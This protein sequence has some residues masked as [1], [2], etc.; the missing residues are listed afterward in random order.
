MTTGGFR[1]VLV[2]MLVTVCLGAGSAGAWAQAGAPVGATA[3][4]FAG[5]TPTGGGSSTPIAARRDPPRRV[6]GAPGD[7]HGQPAGYGGTLVYSSGELVYQDHL[8]DAWG[9]DNGQNTRRLAIQDP[10]AALLPESY[11]LDPAI[12]YVPYEFG[13]PTPGMDIQTHYGA[14]S[15]QEQADLSELRVGTE[16]SRG[17]WLLART[18][19][20]TGPPSTALLVLLDT[21][22]PGASP[23]TVPFNANLKSARADHALLLWGSRGWVADLATGAITELPA[24]S[25]AT[26]PSGYVNAIEAHITP[27]SLGG[28]L[29]DH[30]SI[31]AATGLIDPGHG[32]ALRDLGAGAGLANVANVAFRTSEPARDYWDKQ[33]AL[34]LYQGTI[35]P[36]F[37]GVDIGRLLAGSSEAYQPGPG[38]HDRIFPSEA[39]IS[40][41]RGQEGLLQHYGVYLPSSYRPERPSPVQW[42]F[43]FRGG[44][45]HIAAAL[46]P[47]IFQDMGENVNSIVITPRGRGE[48]S[49]YVGRGQLDFQEVWADVHQLLN[50]DPDRNYIAGHSMGGWAT[51]LMTILY[52]DRF[53]AGFPASGPPT[54]GAWTGVDFAHCDEISADGMSPCY[55]S[56]NGGDARAEFTRPLLDNLRWVPQ[57]IYQGT[58]DELVPVSGVILQAQRLRDLGYRYRLYLFPGQEHYG[59]PIQDQWGEGARY[60]HQFVRD[61]NPPQVTYIRSEPFEH[62]VEHVNAQGAKLTFHFDSA[63]WMSGLEPVDSAQ[64]VARFDGHSLAIPQRP[65]ALLPE[66]GG[67][68]SADQ[69]GPYAMTGQAWQYGGATPDTRNAFDATLT[70]AR[71]VTL[72]SRRMR[73]AARETVTGAVS[74][75]APL[76]LSVLGRFGLNTRARVDGREV[77]PHLMASAVSVDV[78]AGQHEVVFDHPPGAG[79]LGVRGAR[80]CTSRRRFQI[81]L[82]RP[83][84]DRLVSARVLVNGFPAHT[85]RGRRLRANINLHG[86]PRGTVHVTI[87]ARTARGRTLRQQRT[88]HTCRPGHRVRRRSPRPRRGAAGRRASPGQTT[89]ARGRRGAA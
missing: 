16:R 57:A 41:E 87:V 60:E 29:P 85:F 28:A 68:A 31:A 9:P 61:P 25:V 43:H 86:L 15:L 75:Q 82:P 6:D 32:P 35:D 51:Y 65:Y 77:D 56:A 89:G 59:P 12:Q 19:T 78:P 1:A 63:Y 79:V 22:H 70:G 11:R 81:R 13:I 72:D 14:L 50:V 5:E 49:W 2:G 23:R 64:G 24:G 69:T 18:T 20:M 71:A 7:W 44:R 46:V 45:A 58:V 83:R 27:A 34:T 8:F 54:Q 76:R 39:I 33:Q 80:G 30:F 88:Y 55:T 67:P 84:G 48:S 40:Q 52:P 37:A 73:L 62:A 53:A 10:V 21:G 36:F 38:Y 47:R 26:N 17:L 74:T 66:A 4:V 3:P 42:W